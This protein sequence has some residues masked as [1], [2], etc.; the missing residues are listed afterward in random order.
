MRDG[1]LKRTRPT[2]LELGIEAARTI[3]QPSGVA[4]AVEDT[5]GVATYRCREAGGFGA[6][7]PSIIVKAA[8]ASFCRVG[9]RWQFDQ[10]DHIGLNL[11]RNFRIGF[12]FGQ[13][14]RV[15]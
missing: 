10:G 7:S 8:M 3:V 14:S 11:V 4:L 5:W 2:K 1:G 9:A 12:Q 15:R 13:G 6:D